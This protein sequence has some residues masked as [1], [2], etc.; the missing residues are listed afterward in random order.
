MKDSFPSFLC[1]CLQVNRQKTFLGSFLMKQ[2]PFMCV[3]TLFRIASI[4]WP[5]KSPSWTQAWK[6]VSWLDG[7]PIWP[8]CFRLI[9]T[10]LSCCFSFSEGHKH[11]EGIQK[12]CSSEPAGFV[13]KQH[14]QLCGRHVQQ[15]WQASSSHHTLLLQVRCKN[16]PF[17]NNRVVTIHFSKNSIHSKTCDC[18]FG[19]WLILIPYWTTQFLT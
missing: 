7:R 2:T 16:R 13:Q 4:V 14:S 11:E 1:L 6:K 3:Q 17:R 10:P 8:A 18:W 5:S 12:L 15:L 9:L 19:S